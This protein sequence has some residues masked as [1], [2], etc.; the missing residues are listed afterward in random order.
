M[1]E[2]ISCFAC[3]HKVHISATSCPNCGASFKAQNKFNWLAFLFT[4]LYYG[5]KNC[6]PKAYMISALYCI[7]YSPLFIMIYCGLKANK[8]IAPANANTFKWSLALPQV[9]ML[10]IASAISLTILKK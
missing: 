7:P 3:E 10:S 9:L 1:N 2:L 6:Q 4:S 8:D 5:G